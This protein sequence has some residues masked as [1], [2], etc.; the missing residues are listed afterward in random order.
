MKLLSSRTATYVH[1]SPW[2]SETSLE[3]SPYSMSFPLNFSFFSDERPE[4]V[5]LDLFQPMPCCMNRVKAETCSEALTI[6]ARTLS[7]ITSSCLHTAFWLM[8][9]ARRLST[10]TILSKGVQSPKSIVPFRI[11]KGLLLQQLQYPWPL[12]TLCV[13]IFHAPTRPNFAHAE[14]SQY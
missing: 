8:P 7:T 13:M 3:V 11:E 5:Y 6:Q 9:D 12:R 14:L 1:L 4:L 2:G 10:R